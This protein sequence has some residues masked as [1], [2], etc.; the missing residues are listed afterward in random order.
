MNSLPSMTN[1]ANILVAY[2]LD[3]EFTYAFTEEQQI[4]IGSIV[5][6]PFRSKKYL[7]VVRSIGKTTNVDLNKIKSIADVSNYT[8]PQKIL[9]FLDWIASYNLIFKGQVLKMILPK[10]DTYFLLKDE[11]ETNIEQAVANQLELNATQNKAKVEIEAIIQDNDYS[12]ILLDGM[13]GS[14]IRHTH[15][16]DI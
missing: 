12:T 7:G 6:V 4:K 10:S 8:L 9:K 5:L 11:V 15:K 3:Q 16:A 2:P 1:F 13:P 14:H